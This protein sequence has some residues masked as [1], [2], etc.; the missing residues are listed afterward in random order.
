[1][2]TQLCGINSAVECQLPKLKV[3]GSNPVSRSNQAVARSASPPPQAERRRALASGTDAIERDECVFATELLMLSRENARE[4]R[5]GERLQSA[6]FLRRDR[7]LGFDHQVSPDP[8]GSRNR[9]PT[10][11]T[12]GL[13]GEASP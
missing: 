11:A 13:R 10:H 8:K 6:Q 2:F 5:D 9:R 1:M 4:R 3:A 12:E 7:S